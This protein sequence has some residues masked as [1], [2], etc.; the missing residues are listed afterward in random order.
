MEDV[1]QQDH[2]EH[3]TCMHKS[4]SYLCVT[5]SKASHLDSDGPGA[6]GGVEGVADG[7][8]HSVPAQLE[9]P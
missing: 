7:Q 9:R 6:A 4:I 3:E 8:L 2:P 1:G 5:I